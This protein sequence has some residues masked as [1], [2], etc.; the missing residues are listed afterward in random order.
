[1]KR[2]LIAV[3]AIAL[4]AIAGWWRFLRPDLP[5]AERGRRLAERSGCFACHGPEG[6]R[7]AEN[8]GRADGSVPNYQGDV[9]MYAKSAE[10]LREWIRDGV[11]EARSK[12]RTWRRERD[13]GALRM[14]AFG[15]RLDAREIEELVAFVQVQSGAGEPEDSLAERGLERAADLGCTGCHGPG[16][17][18]ARPNPGSLKGYVPAW[19]GRDFAELVRDR[20]EFD[21]WVR[22]GV[23]R[24]FERN[25]LAIF[26]LRRA[27]LQMPAYQRHL[28]PGDLDAL[29][30]YVQWLR[31]PAVSE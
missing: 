27:V 21:Q 1:M 24:R 6:T 2:L 14:P 15:H 30:A 11:T 28:A 19:D 3:V 7:G 17:R 10:E 12:S 13:R 23:S 16:G 18:L 8:P 9:M 25:A 4:L 5:A 31:A 29:W 20:D 22:R 26:F